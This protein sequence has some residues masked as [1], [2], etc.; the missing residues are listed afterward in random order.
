MIKI[1]RETT[2]VVDGFHYQPHLYYVNEQDKLV[3]FQVADYSRGLDKFSKPKK[4]DTR[5]RKF[6]QI[7]TVPELH[8]DDIVEVTSSSGNT[9]Q[10]NLNT[11]RCS[12][13]GFKFHGKCRHLDMAVK[14]AA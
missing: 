3:W 14:K 10:V 4:F 6:E 5:R 12:C 11:N 7:G 9:Y 8:D 13:R 1:L 2:G